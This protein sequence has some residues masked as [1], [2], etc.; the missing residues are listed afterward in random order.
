MKTKRTGVYLLDADG[1]ATTD[2]YEHG[3]T[4]VGDD[5]L[6]VVRVDD[7][8]EERLIIK[9]FVYDAINETL[10]FVREQGF[11]YGIKDREAGIISGTCIDTTYYPYTDTIYATA[12]GQ[13]QPYKRFM[14]MGLTGY[15]LRREVRMNGDT[16][17]EIEY[18]QSGLIKERKVFKHDGYVERTVY[19]YDYS[20]RPAKLIE[21]VRVDG[22]SDE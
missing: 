16:E 4:Y 13:T 22:D 5:V 8:D 12:D 7:I 15:Y 20:Y 9:S 14:E 2:F 6:R 3:R 19:H 17:L 11:E 10:L 18:N 1:Y 21:K